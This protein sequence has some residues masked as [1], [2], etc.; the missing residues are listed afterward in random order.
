MK[1]VEVLWEL[2]QNVKQRPK[3]SKCFWKKKT[4]LIDL[5]N[6]GLAQTFSLLK[7]KNL[8]N[9]CMEAHRLRKPRDTCIALRWC[10]V[11]LNIFNL[12]VA[13]HGIGVIPVSQSPQALSGLY[14]LSS[15]IELIKGRAGIET[16]VHL[17]LCSCR[18]WVY[19][20]W[21]RAFLSG[22]LLI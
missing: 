2:Y 11:V 4:A 20:H 9:A 8:Q 12:R 6:A 21:F 17:A 13:L 16:W 10:S 22:Y 7:K 14:N 3:V 1:K 5:L 18:D 19:F 15:D